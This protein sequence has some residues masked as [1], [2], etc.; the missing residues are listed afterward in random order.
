MKNNITEQMHSTLFELICSELGT[1][2]TELTISISTSIT[3]KIMEQ[4]QPHQMLS[5]LTELR[6][7]YV[8]ELNEE[9]GEPK[10]AVK[11]I[12]HT[13]QQVNKIIDK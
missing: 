5:L 11:D 12:I 4:I 2:R 13:W 3:N 1:Y 10:A 6:Q 8:Y 7:T 9:T